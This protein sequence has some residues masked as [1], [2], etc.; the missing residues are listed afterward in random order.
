MSQFEYECALSGLSGAGGPH[1]TLDDLD[2]LP[3]GW[4]EVRLSRR[5]YNPK[6]VAIQRTKQGMIAA[7]LAQLPEGAGI[8]QQV[9][10]RLQVEASFHGL[11]KDTPMYLTDVET[12]YLAPPETA[13]ELLEAYN[14]ARQS[15]G[16]EPIVTAEEPSE[17]EDEGKAAS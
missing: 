7:L 6:W 13:E 12:V 17:E 16:L 14:E 11:E 5:M 15:L 2:D 9:S 1:F 4:T 8:D 3:P 10:I